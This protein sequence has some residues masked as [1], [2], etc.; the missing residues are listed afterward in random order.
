MWLWGKVDVVH[1]LVCYDLTEEEQRPP[2]KGSPKDKC[3]PLYP[4]MYNEIMPHDAIEL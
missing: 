2:E 3:F 4:Q 1:C